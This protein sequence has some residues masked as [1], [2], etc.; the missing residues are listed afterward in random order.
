LTDIFEVVQDGLPFFRD[1]LPGVTTSAQK[2]FMLLLQRQ[3]LRLADDLEAANTQIGRSS[4][5]EDAARRNTTPIL[6]APVRIH[7]AKLLEDKL[8]ETTVLQLEGKDKL[9]ETT[10]L[11][12]EGEDG[13]KG[14]A[15][16][17]LEGAR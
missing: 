9:Q 6:P 1:L 3:A 16:L 5:V 8:K 17:Q 10:V 7:E 15:V 11:Q 14:T 4:H 13:L 12:L 2:F